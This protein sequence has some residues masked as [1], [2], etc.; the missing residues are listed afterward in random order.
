MHPAWYEGYCIECGAPCEHSFDAYNDYTCIYCGMQ[1]LVPPSEYCSHMW[2]SGVCSY[3]GYTCPHETFKEGYCAYCDFVCYHVNWQGGVCDLCGFTC[4]H[5]FYHGR[6]EYCNTD[7]SY[8]SET[9][10]V[11]YEGSEYT[12][13]FGTLLSEFV[14]SYLYMDFEMSTMR[15]MWNITNYDSAYNLDGGI[16]FCDYGNEIYLEYFSYGM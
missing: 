4:N 1:A 13:P 6:C 15:G 2:Y 10:T 9:I 14:S 7:A 3:C 12:V 8:I 16:Y 11:Y 5:Y